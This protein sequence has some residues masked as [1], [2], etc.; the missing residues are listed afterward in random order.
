MYISDYITSKRFIKVDY[1]KHNGL[2]FASIDKK[3]DK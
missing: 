3:E 2:G 1:L